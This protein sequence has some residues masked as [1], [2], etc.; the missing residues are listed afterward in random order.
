MDKNSFYDTAA[1]KNT[2]LNNQLTTPISEYN[3]S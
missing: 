3:N 2:K 1:Q